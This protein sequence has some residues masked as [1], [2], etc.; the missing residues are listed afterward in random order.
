MQQLSLFRGV[1]D[2]QPRPVTLEELVTMMRTDQSVRDLTEKHRYARATGDEL[3]ASRYKKMMPNFGVAARFE[4]GRQQKH[5]VEY[6]GLSLVDIDHIPPERMT[7]V[8]DLVRADEHTLLAYT[9][10]SGHGVRILA[11]YALNTSNDNDNVN[12]DAGGAS[13]ATTEPLGSP[14]STTLS[15]YCLPDGKST[16][17]L[18]S[19]F[20]NY[21]QAFLTVN[22]YY[23]H[24]TGLATDHQCKNIGRI[25]TIAYDENLYY[26]PDATPFIVKLEEK[27]PVGRP[28]KDES[29]CR[30]S[31]GLK[32]KMTVERCEAHV[33]REL[34][35]RGVVYAPGTHNKYISDACYMMNRYGVALDDCTAWA[36]DKFG[37]YQAE[38]NDVASIVR[39]C[40]AQTDEHG[41]AKMTRS[42]E[43]RYASIKEI[44]DWLTE[45]KIKIRHN[46]IT[47]K[48]EISFNDN[49]NV[50]ADA[51]RA[52]VATAEALA[53][54]RSA[55]S[56]PSCHPD[57]WST[58]TSSSTLIWKELEDKSV[59]SLYCRF[60]LD[61]GRQ[62]K[63][64]DFYIII[65][66]DFYPEYNPLWEY[67]D[68]LPAWDGKTDY[69]DQ[70]ASSVHV[71]GCTQ[72]MHNRFFKKWM[73]A[74]VAAWLDDGVTNHE[75]LTY[76]GEQGKYKTSFMTHLLP[77]ALDKY[78]AIKHFNHSMSKDDR[79][80]LTELALIDLEELDNLRPE[81]VNL[82][83][84]VTTDPAI[85]L[86]PVWE[87]YALR[88]Q[89]IASFC[90]TGNNPRFLTDL[91]GNRRWLA[92]MV[93]SIDSPWERITDYD[94]LYAQVYALWRQGFRYWFDDEENA[95]LQRHNRQFEE[96]N[97]EEELILTYLRQPYGEEMGE[98]LTATRII[99]LVGM[100]VK[101]QLSPKR[102]AY[103]MNRLGYRQR[104]VGGVRGYN[105]V[106]LTGDM[107]KEQ[108]R[109]NARESTLSE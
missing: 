76:I 61:T 81:A 92:F 14:R 10:L 87:R 103:A 55:T 105:V 5:I 28:R 13:V 107:I 59:N 46:V 104:R 83:K 16:S 32:S 2:T 86:R 96:P 30:R 82:L 75:I 63:I 4:G 90:G 84:A 37:D 48:R 58:S 70:L 108:Q 15:S 8:L 72:E 74:M 69:I 109:L 71:T 23:S 9:T 62:A 57:G 67:L 33:L 31:Q 29:G 19:T 6:T 40:Y 64:N 21:K 41:T 24:L 18:T 100:Y 50:N 65:E 26:N 102:V 101:C 98:F 22:T 42:T 106:I 3:G 44:Q 35:Q 12:A 97:I 25:S 49:D 66:S 38:G 77:P 45:K 88:R 54:L 20:S 79:L 85:N 17:T 27:K 89:H 43:S 36:L 56:S 7:E 91:S 78:F 68:N 95:E 1:H 53:S 52:S 34:E 51:G 94:G 39:S 11:R 99:E 47:R 80:A 93:N 73:V 60:C